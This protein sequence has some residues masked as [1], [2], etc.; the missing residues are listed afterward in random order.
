M[1]MSAS[2]DCIAAVFFGH[3]GGHERRATGLVG[4]FRRPPMRDGPGCGEAAASGVIV[5][6]CAV[7]TI[8]ALVNVKRLDGRSAQVNRPA[9]GQIV[10]QR[11]DGRSSHPT[12]VRLSGSA[13]MAVPKAG[14]AV[15]G[16]WRRRSDCRAAR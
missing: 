3:D 7:Q 4:V 6:A 12:T 16:V 13:V 15:M 5:I 2:L 10:G 14:S 11:G 9:D 1:V 8:I